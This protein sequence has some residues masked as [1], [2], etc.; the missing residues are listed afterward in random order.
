[1][2]NKIIFLIIMIILLSNIVNAQ[3]YIPEDKNINKDAIINEQL[4]NLN[5]EELEKIIKKINS[6]TKD[7]IPKIDFKSYLSSLVKGKKVVTVDEIIK[8]IL[9][10]TFSEVIE[11]ISLILKLLALSIAC[12]ILKNLQNAFEKDTIS[13]LANYVC[14]IVIIAVIIKS[15][16]VAIGIGKDSIGQMVTFMQAL[17]PTLITLLAAMG[18]L[19]SSALFQPI[20]LGSLGAIST[21]MKDIILPLV[22]FSAVIG[23]V[24]KISNR[25]QFSKVSS[26]IRE[27]SVIIIGILLT[28]FVGIISIQGETASKFDGITIRTAKFA[29]GSFI[30]IAGSFLSDAVDTVIGCSMLLKNAIGV[31]GLIVLFVICIIPCIKI[32]SLILVYKITIAVIEPISDS[33]IVDCLNEVSK[34]LIIVFAT[35]FSVCL[36]FFIAITIIISAGNI[37]AMLS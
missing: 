19:A 32:I 1:M 10:L 14:Y 35:I 29:I 18:G 37:T 26:L 22:F 12:A 33:N 3:D 36:M 11:N 24:S 34:S 17:L 23:I 4:R 6:E 31:I 8:G 5:T 28:V 21:I 2:K 16:V 13:K 30:P 15:F 7:Y 27:V 20:I 9:K 25:I